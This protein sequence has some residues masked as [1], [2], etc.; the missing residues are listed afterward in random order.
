LLYPMLHDFGAW[1]LSWHSGGNLRDFNQRRHG[2]IV[3]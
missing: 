3:R 1:R 2:A